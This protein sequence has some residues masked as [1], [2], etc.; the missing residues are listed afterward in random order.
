MGT[1]AKSS[2]RKSSIVPYANPIDDE[3]SSGVDK[4]TSEM[5]HERQRERDES[6]KQRT[7]TESLMKRR[8]RRRCC[9]VVVG[10]GVFVVKCDKYKF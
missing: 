10:G 1:N 3:S 8:R 4:A 6:G 7:S 2:V 9:G 5:K